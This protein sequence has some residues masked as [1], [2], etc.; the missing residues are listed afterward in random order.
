[1]FDFQ[2]NADNFCLAFA[3]RHNFEIESIYIEHLGSAKKI[4]KQENLDF[5][6]TL[7][8]V[9]DDEFSISF[10]GL[11]TYIFPFEE[12][13][14]WINELLDGI[15]SGDCRLKNYYQLGTLKKSVLE[16]LKDLS[17]IHI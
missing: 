12:K 13:L 10:E 2:R 6:L 1:M 4:K 16:Q 11:N 8:L 5:D 15:V 14:D 17:L 7:F 3:K 9:A